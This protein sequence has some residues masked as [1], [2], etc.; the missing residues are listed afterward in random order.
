MFSL[1]FDDGQHNR[2]VSSHLH[3]DFFFK[4]VKKKKDW[5]SGFDVAVNSFKCSTKQT[6]SVNRLVMWLPFP[7]NDAHRCFTAPS[8]APSVNASVSKPGAM[9][10]NDGRYF[11]ALLARAA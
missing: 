4:K 5:S 1:M 2:S 8:Q 7:S 3:F 10:L 11:P 6:N 9:L